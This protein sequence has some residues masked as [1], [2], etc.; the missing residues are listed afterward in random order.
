MGGIYCAKRIALGCVLG[1][2]SSKGG[3]DRNLVLTILLLFATEIVFLLL[4]R[5][6]E[7]IS[8]GLT[9]QVAEEQGRKKGRSV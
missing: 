6:Y 3:I 5:R 7:L 2:A 9:E 4:R 8:D 1:I